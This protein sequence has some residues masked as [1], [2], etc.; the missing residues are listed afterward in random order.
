MKVELGQGTKK[1]L[2]PPNGSRSSRR[3]A[4]TVSGGVR[5]GL[6]STGLRTMMG[7]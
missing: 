2:A 6:G 5:I 1:E 4:A 7:D 3:S